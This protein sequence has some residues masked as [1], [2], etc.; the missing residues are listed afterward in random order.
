MFAA[1][2]LGRTAPISSMRYELRSPI[3][4]AFAF[5][6]VGKLMHYISRFLVGFAIGFFRVWQISL[7]TLSMLPLIGLAGGIY[8]YITIGLIINVRKSY[9][10]AGQ[11]VQEVIGNI[12]TVQSFTGEERA[13]RS[14]KE[15][16]RDAYKHGKKAGLAKGLGMGTLQSIVFLSWALL[17]WYTSIVVHKNIANGGDSF[18]TMLNVLIAGV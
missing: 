18:T 17:V 16:L 5:A 12:R 8:A 13:V 1:Y 9:V 3:P 10:E 2:L 11:I 14:Y 7:V 6:M 4:I 15:A